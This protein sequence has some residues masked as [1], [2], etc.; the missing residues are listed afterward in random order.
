MRDY[1]MKDDT[2]S[3][4]EALTRR[5]M[6]VPSA[7][8]TDDGNPFLD[9]ENGIGRALLRSLVENDGYSLIA[10]FE[11]RIERKDYRFFELLGRV[12]ETEG[13]T[14]TLHERYERGLKEIRTELHRR[15]EEAQ[16]AIEQGT[17]DG[18]L[19]EV[20]RARLSAAVEAVA[21]NESLNF[22]PLFE[23]ID[24]IED[25]LRERLETRV[26]ELETSWQKIRPN[27]DGS[28]DSDQ[29]RI[30]ERFMMDAF[31]ARDTRVIE[32]SIA[33][34]REFSTGD[35]EWKMEWF[36]PPAPRE[37]F[38]EFVKAI[39]R[40]ESELNGVDDLS[41]IA[42]RI[43]AEETGSNRRGDTTTSSQGN[44]RRKVWTAW[45]GLKLR[46]GGELEPYLTTIVRFIGFVLD[47]TVTVK[48]SQRDM[49]HCEAILASV[50]GDYESGHARPI[51]QFG[52]QANG[53]LDVCC[54][55]ERPGTDSIRTF[56]S[57]PRFEKKVYVV[58]YLGRLHVARR[59]A[60]AKWS[61]ERNLSVAVV[62]ETL[63][64]FL[65]QCSGVRLPL[66]L[67]CSLPYTAINP[68]T[69]FQAGSVPAEIFYGRQDMVNLIQEPREGSCIVFGG[70]QLGKSA[71]LNQVQ[72]EFNRPS[73]EQFAWVED[74][75]TIGDPVTGEAAELLWIRL[76]DGFKANGLLKEH[77]RANEPRNIMNHIQSAMEAS[78]QRRVIVLFDEADHFLDSDARAGF[79]V[80]DGLR[81]LIQRSDLRL[82]VVFAGLHD[83]QRFKNISNQPL[84]HFGR[85]LLV[86]PL[87]ADAA[88][89]LVVEPMTA[90]GYRFSD[91]KAALKVLSYTNYHPGLI[92]Y[93]CRELLHRL[94]RRPRGSGPPYEVHS[95][96]V[97]AV[98][99]LRR[100][101]EIIRERLDWTLALDVRYQCIAWAMIYEQKDVRDSYARL[102]SVT[103]ILELAM[104]Y[105]TE[106][107][108][109][110]D[111]ERLGG[112][113]GEMVG[114]GVLVRNLENQY[115]LRSPNLVRLMGTEEDIE[116]RL[117]ELSDISRP[118]QSQPDSQHYLLQHDEK[119]PLYSPL[120]LVQE[121][122]LLGSRESRVS[123]VF[124]SEALGLDV[125]SQALKRVAG[126]VGKP[127]PADQS[128]QADRMVSWLEGFAGGRQRTEQLLTY[129]W[130]N[131][132]GT[133]MARCITKVLDM[134]RGFN[135][136]RRRPLRVVFVLNAEASWSWMKM[137]KG[138]REILENRADVI[139]LR[140]WNEVG[141]QQRLSRVEKLD[142]PDVCRE[143]LE[144]TGG[145][146]PLLEELFVR[147]G[148]DR[149]PRPHGATL[150]TDTMEPGLS[151]GV[152]L[153]QQVGIGS[154]DSWPHRV[155]CALVEYDGVLED[156]I[157]S[158]VELIDPERT[159]E[160]AQAA[161][162]YL[163]RMGC[164][165]RTGGRYQAEP[166]LGNVI[167]AE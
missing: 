113:L 69:P 104:K 162:G 166:V 110:F 149:D 85:N 157:R 154:E 79:G 45:H 3:L 32:E 156:D 145:W 68:Y 133:E 92:Q 84:A 138:E 39:P 41:E 56:L 29:V 106:G 158:L 142:L 13:N 151:L 81:S 60:L 90:L 86:G 38:D 163:E 20:E 63:L 35:S 99:R 115:L 40:I 64:V 89:R 43:V 93:F 96:D 119:N 160:D 54:L 148:A 22:G 135:Q 23:R 15:V 140:R 159:T 108:T 27:L 136:R 57:D 123:L 130:L 74:I 83:V 70:R 82:K 105:W 21:T 28:I 52:S 134:C 153:L 126:E 143:V 25:Q 165:E 18:L 49:L 33:R 141:I 91:T 11:K 100:T 12:S 120:T 111:T 144:A 95:V 19:L 101:R 152:Q 7:E 88:R 51:P 24:E 167:G 114:L 132:N 36:D 71:L 66:F 107:F 80:V 59:V 125:L 76:R 17:V 102:F 53:R 117:L 10:A 31:T 30:V 61:R 37:V 128:I 116:S 9:S 1:W 97:E 5:L 109:G 121:G 44:G 4:H 118:T 137:A 46:N 112:L 127:I 155:L 58:L 16:D 6:L 26:R 67:R 48:K 94:Q 131:G 122:L 2:G 87:E 150:L 75:K 73:A 34:L 62:D 55:W 164:V 147:C 139:C 72:R 47:A 146:N 161:L 50:E 14:P 77:V 124:G 129:G 42:E 65:S 78:P 8:L 98:Y 103:E